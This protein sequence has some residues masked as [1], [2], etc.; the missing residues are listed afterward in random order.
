MP[1]Q[2]GVATFVGQFAAGTEPTITINE[3]PYSSAAITWDISSVNCSV[4]E[5]G[6]ME[7]QRDANG[8]VVGFI[9]GERMKTLEMTAKVKAT[10]KAAALAAVILATRGAT[11][12]LAKFLA[13]SG[14]TQ[15]NGEYIVQ[16]GAKIEVSDSEIEPAKISFTAIQY[17]TAA[18]TL[19]AA[20][21]DTGS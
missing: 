21:P 12:T 18:S 2:T 8:K 11:V 19:L 10:N 4:T 20:V 7:P 17:E 9:L 5:G 3:L 6:E 14:N 13:A 16:P 15:I 1:T